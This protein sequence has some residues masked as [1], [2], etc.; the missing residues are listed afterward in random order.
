MSNLSEIGMNFS[1][2]LTSL[3]PQI[4]NNSLQWYLSGSLATITMAQAE[5][6]TEIELDEN[7]NIRGE[8]NTKEISIEQKEKL[9]KFSRKLGADI[10]VVN[11]NG[12][13]FDEAP[14][15]NKPHI[16]NIIQ[17]VPDVLDLMSWSRSMGGT[18]YIDNLDVEREIP[19]H[20]VA[21]IKT[22]NGDLYV[23]APPEQLAHKLS[24]TIWFSHSLCEGRNSE[25]RM[26]HYEKDIKDFSSM[27]YGFKDLYEDDEFF[28]RVYKALNEKDHSLFSIL[29]Y[30]SADLESSLEEHDV[31]EKTVIQKIIDD[32][33]KYIET[34]ADDKSAKEL[35]DFLRNLLITRKNDLESLINNRPSNSLTPLQK[36]EFELSELEAKAK[37]YDEKLKSEKDK[38]EEICI[39]E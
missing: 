20:P 33:T 16:Q 35:E 24:E 36:R 11:V 3:S 5:N 28:S 25:K 17:N 2:Y 31:F 39:G 18:M 15:S 29:D 27:F 21:K 9:E 8:K 22:A 26:A 34:I 30:T 12:D 6:I 10:D 37:E 32:S 38:Q 14:L 1:T 4:K 13:F 23:T 7:N 19:Y